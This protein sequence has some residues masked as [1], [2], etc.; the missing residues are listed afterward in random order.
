MQ[1]ADKLTFCFDV[2]FSEGFFLQ[3]VGNIQEEYK[4][5][6]IKK[7]IVKTEEQCWEQLIH[8]RI[9]PKYFQITNCDW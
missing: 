8:E 2:Y 7:D 1:I 6:T 5:N 4:N 3:Q 9:Y